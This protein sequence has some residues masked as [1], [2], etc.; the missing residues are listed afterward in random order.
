MTLIFNSKSIVRRTRPKTPQPE[1]LVSLARVREI[2][3]AAQRPVAMAIAMIITVLS[4]ALCLLYFRL[5]R[6]IG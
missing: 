2:M 1:T 5:G 3:N 6:R 4:A